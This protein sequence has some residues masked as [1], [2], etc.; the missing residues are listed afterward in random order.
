MLTRELEKLERQSNETLQAGGN[1]TALGIAIKTQ[2]VDLGVEALRTLTSAIST[3]VSDSFQVSDAFRGFDVALES[4]FGSAQAA[5]QELDFLRSTVNEFGGDIQGATQ[6]YIS[7]SAAANEAGVDQ[8]AVREV[9][10]E[11]T[12]VL[13]LFG[14]SAEQSNL[15]LNALSQIA[16]KGVVSMEELRQQ[17][18]EQLPVAF[19]ATARGLGI[20]TAELNELV[21]S[22]ELT[23]AEFFPAFA[24]GLADI[25]GQIDPAVLA[26]QRFNN[27]ITE[28]QRGIG[29][30]LTPIRTAITEFSASVLS[31]AGENFDGFDAITEAANRLNI[32]LNENPEVVRRI[33]AALGELSNTA[34]QEL[35]EIIDAITVFVSDAEN[36]EAIQLSIENLA[37]ALSLLGETVSFLVALTNTIIDLDRAVSGIDP[38]DGN[39][40]INFLRRINPLAN[41][42]FRALDLLAIRMQQL[43]IVD[44]PGL[45]AFGQQLTDLTGQAQDAFADLAEAAENLPQSVEAPETSALSEEEISR[46]VDDER[47]ARQQQFDREKFER[48][49]QNAE[50]IADI[51]E[52]RQEEIDADKLVV[53]EEINQLKLEG[54]Q[55]IEDLKLAREAELE[56]FKAAREAALQ[57]RERAFNENERQLEDAF[58]ERQRQLDEDTAERIR[59]LESDIDNQLELEFADN[60]RERRDIARRQAEEE[61]RARREEELRAQAG[62]DDIERQREAE[63]QQAEL[64]FEQQQFERQRA[65]EQALAVERA[66]LDEQL[67]QARLQ[68]ETTVLQPQREALEDRLNQRRLELLAPIAEAEEQLERDIAELRFQN[69]QEE[70]RI[71][72]DFDQQQAERERALKEDLA[73]VE[74]AASQ[75]AAENLRSGAQDAK[76]ILEST[77]LRTALQNGAEISSLRGGGTL[78]PHQVARVHRD[79]YVMAGQQGATVVNQARSRAINAAAMRAENTIIRT[80]RIQMEAMAKEIK[81]LRADIA[82]RQVPRLEQTIISN[83][84]QA[85]PAREIAELWDVRF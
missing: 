73:N 44:T 50:I 59:N 47:F 61:A 69:Q 8:A 31:E 45:E 4:V 70:Q 76:D 26:V 56:D 68:F 37:G 35:G 60:P 43:G 75:V 32:A 36:I 16:S 62:I 80:N 3:F 48:D 25:E 63:R 9:F 41:A 78:Q 19:G 33:G 71:Q 39:P 85:A 84:V 46:R 65:N 58:N 72:R 67:N 64:T 40:L 82:R 5:S 77:Q 6:Q 22:G 30:A 14:R 7:L 74:V 51:Q 54:E 10:T 20:T 42:A 18:G 23:A 83:G 52:E 17:L 1:L 21:S 57:E 28:I 27:S 24:R 53:E 11:T 81:G 12:R 29:N 13:G 15:T 38:D 49:R 66:S 2:L 79:E 34:V 55:A